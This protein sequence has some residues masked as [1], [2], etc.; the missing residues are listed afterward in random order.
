MADSRYTTRF[1]RYRV[2]IKY[3]GET[4]VYETMA[5]TEAGAKA[6]ALCRAA[7]DL[8][9]LVNLLHSKVR[10]GDLLITVEQIG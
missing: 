7:K 4:L 9:T 8:N 10:S 2:V 1:N 6:N 5:K 3:R